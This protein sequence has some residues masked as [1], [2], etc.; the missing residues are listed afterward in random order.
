[1]PAH[2]RRIIVRSKSD[3]CLVLRDTFATR[4]TLAVP[5]VLDVAHEALYERQ[6]RSDRGLDRGILPVFFRCG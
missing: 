5:P 4:E 3:R 6:G 2:I 1:M